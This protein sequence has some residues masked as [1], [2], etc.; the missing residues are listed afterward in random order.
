MA[1]TSGGGL[2]GIRS[3]VNVTP[4]IDVLLVLLIIFMVIV[5]VVPKGESSLLPRPSQQTNQVDAAVVVSVLSSGTDG[6]MY[7]INR[8]SVAKGELLARLTAIYANRA[9]RVLFVQG[10]DELNY[11]EIAQ[12]IDTGHS[13]GATEVGLMSKKVA[14]EKQ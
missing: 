13:A 7:R 11:S 2:K 5:P 12:V 4:M 8:Q 1:M 10:D 14:A 6:V 3:E 9:S